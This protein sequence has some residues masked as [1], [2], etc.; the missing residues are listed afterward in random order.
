[1][2]ILYICIL[3]FFSL[4]FDPNSQLNMNWSEKTRVSGTGGGGD[5][6]GKGAV[7]SSFVFVLDTCIW[8]E[9]VEISVYSKFNF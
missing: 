2:Y 3:T 8:R 1:M 4:V 6:L 7:Y 5:G 9:Q